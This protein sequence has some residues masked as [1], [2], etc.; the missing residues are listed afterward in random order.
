MGNEASTGNATSALKATKRSSNLLLAGWQ[1]RK[2]PTQLFAVVRHTERADGV[3]AFWENGRWSSSEDC[4]RFPLDPPLSDAGHEQAE[5][6]GVDIRQFAEQKG[7]DFHVVV[8]SPYSRCVQ[9]AVKICQHLGPKAKMLID[10]SLGEIYGPSVMG[11]AQPRD[12]LRAFTVAVDYCRA[13]DVP[14]VTR[15][16]G[17]KPVWPESLQDARRRFALRF[18]QYLQR[19][20]VAKRNFLIVTHGDC[21]GSVMSIMPEQQDL[22]VEKVDY[23]ATILASRQPV[24][25]MPAP[26]PTQSAPRAKGMA[27]V[28]PM[29]A[30]EEVMVEGTG[31]FRLQDGLEHI[32]EGLE[33]T[34]GSGQREPD[35]WAIPA[36]ADKG[37]PEVNKLTQKVMTGWNCETM[38]ISVRHKKSKGY[39]LAKR[40]TALVESGPFSMQKVEKLL[41]AI[42]QTP[43][44]DSTPLP[45]TP[46]NHST[47]LSV[48]SGL[49]ASTYLFGGSQLDS[50][51]FNPFVPPSPDAVVQNQRVLS[52]QLDFQ[53]RK[54]EM[55]HMSQRSASAVDKLSMKHYLNPLEGVQ[56]ADLERSPSKHAG[57]AEAVGPSEPQRKVSSPSL[58]LDG[59]ISD[60]PYSDEGS[61]VSLMSQEDGPGKPSAEPPPVPSPVVPAKPLNSS[62]DT[63][64]TAASAA[65]SPVPKPEEPKKN[66]GAPGGS[67]LLARRRAS[68]GIAPLGQ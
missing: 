53:K 68:L 21:I 10:H 33:D 58:I 14:V 64:F 19:G 1:K 60:G 56:E 45:S 37:G 15:A 26:T 6:L 12:H 7:T 54:M 62:R 51:D 52:S 47:T 20:A 39:K 8:C 41:G 42:P 16:V 36:D 40:L 30:E 18:L 4:R 59:R 61:H 25:R 28:M 44:G 29:S 24:Q 13:H 22:L 50:E 43:L 46:A 3:F 38:H 66:F 48:Q 57:K 49:S 65:S 55:S 34:E 9:T 32:A 5:V 27:S 31:D 2:L 67:S 17:Q 11:E 63:T 35:K 23:G